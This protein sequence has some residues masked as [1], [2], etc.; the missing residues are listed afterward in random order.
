MNNNSSFHYCLQ[1]DSSSSAQPKTHRS[2][3]VNVIADDLLTQQRNPASSRTATSQ[4]QCTYS[5]ARSG[6]INTNTNSYYHL[7]QLLKTKQNSTQLAAQS[8]VP[9][10]YNL[11]NPGPTM[12][13]SDV[14]K[15]RLIDFLKAEEERKHTR[16]TKRGPNVKTQAKRWPRISNILASAAHKVYASAVK[17]TSSSKRTNHTQ[18]CTSSSTP[19]GFQVLQTT[20]KAGSASPEREAQSTAGKCQPNKIGLMQQC[21]LRTESSK[22]GEVEEQLFRCQLCPGKLPCEY[23]KQ[24]LSDHIRRWHTSEPTMA[25]VDRVREEE[26]TQYQHKHWRCTSTKCKDDN[27]CSGVQR[28]PHKAENTL[29]RTWRCMSKE[30]QGC[31]PQAIRRQYAEAHILYKSE[32]VRRKTD[33]YN[34]KVKSIQRES[35]SGRMF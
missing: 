23:T 14:A 27:M 1:D 28:D 24:G 20:R 17:D 15:E 21:P 32:K 3:A 19:K 31:D 7:K 4:Q 2:G 25:M 22:H 6:V 33:S 9:Q 18:H 35:A 5:D 16:A 11:S 30:R 8:M 34:G 12:L 29:Q 10:T 13:D 26:N